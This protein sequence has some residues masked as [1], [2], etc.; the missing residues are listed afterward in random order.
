MAAARQAS[1][2]QTR[3]IRSGAEREAP[4]ESADVESMDP[5]PDHSGADPC[6]PPP[7]RCGGES[8]NNAGTGLDDPSR[9]INYARTL[10]TT[11]R[12]WARPA[13]VL[14]GAIG[15]SSP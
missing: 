12:F 2:T 9:Q 13:L 10:M 5:T 14:F 8:T 1:R 15:F 4:C 6:D 7:I 11:R 3:R